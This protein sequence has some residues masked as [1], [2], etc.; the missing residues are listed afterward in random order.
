MHIRQA[1]RIKDEGYF[2]TFI[3]NP[4]FCI[5]EI[6][7]FI[8]CNK[9]YLSDFQFMTRNLH[10]PSEYFAGINVFSTRQNPGA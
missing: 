3:F 10:I 5:L 7:F 8:Q 2:F 6:S 1:I 4:I 9:T